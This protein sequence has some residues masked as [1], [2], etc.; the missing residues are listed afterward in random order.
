MSLDTTNTRSVTS[1]AVLAA[2]LLG[3]A[4]GAAWTL[5]SQSSLRRSAT[6]SITPVNLQSVFGVSPV[7]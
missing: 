5:S 7:R 1:R 2:L 6:A 3:A 4:I